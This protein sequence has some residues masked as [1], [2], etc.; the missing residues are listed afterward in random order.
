MAREVVDRRRVDDPV[1]GAEPAVALDVPWRTIFRLLFVAALL[2]AFLHLGNLLTVLVLAVIFAVTI[3]PV[4]A[5]AERH[6]VNKGVA[7]LLVGAVV[8][9]ALAA[10]AEFATPI[11]DEQVR[12]LGTRLDATLAA[13][14]AD[15]PA[16]VDEL[17]RKPAGNTPPITDIAQHAISLGQRIATDLMLGV[18]AF[19]LSLYLIV[20]GERTYQWLL[21]YVPRHNRPRVGCD[22]ARIAPPDRRLCD[23][24]P[25]Y[26]GGC[27][28][29]RLH[30][31]GR[32]ASAGVNGPR[33]I[34]RTARP[35]ARRGLSR[36]HGDGDD[37][38]RGRVACGGDFRV[39]G[40][41]RL[42]FL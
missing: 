33:A 36:V 29:L 35:G 31:A 26:V 32:I 40:V 14:R 3:Q 7:A 8:L 42:P 2:W 38:G 28:G 25:H 1:E 23:R 12:T 41:Q 39:A 22:G 20:E 10:G 30:R 17:L 27:R 19:V 15:V 5:F 4:I 6:G 34:G 18:F 37:R 11:V 16:P 9:A 24:Q 21:A 13:I